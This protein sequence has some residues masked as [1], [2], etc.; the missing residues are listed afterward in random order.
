MLSTS[1]QRLS[2]AF[3]APAPADVDMSLAE[4]LAAL[5]ERLGV[6]WDKNI[7]DG[8]PGEPG[9]SPQA[10]ALMIIGAVVLSWL[11][12]ATIVMAFTGVPSL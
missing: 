11:L 9:Y 5:A 1:I 7:L 12:I 2:N 10:R 3:V 4:A 6:T 8:Y